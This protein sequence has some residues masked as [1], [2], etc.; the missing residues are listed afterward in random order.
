[1]RSA[2]RRGI[3][4]SFPTGNQPGTYSQSGGAQW[5]PRLIGKPLI[6]LKLIQEAVDQVVGMNLA[7]AN[8]LEAENPKK[9]AKIVMNDRL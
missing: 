8:A 3:R 1:L 6:D 2:H 4:K 7:R 5:R 9:K